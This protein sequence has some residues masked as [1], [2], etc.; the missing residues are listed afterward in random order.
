[1][2]NFKIKIVSVFFAAAFAVSGVALPYGAKAAAVE[3]Y[4]DYTVR[5][6]YSKTFNDI[7]INGSDTESAEGGDIS[8]GTYEDISNALIW[9]SQDGS[10]SYKFKTEGDISCNIK[11]SY[12][13]ISDN[14]ADFE[15]GLLIDGQYPFE[16]AGSLKLP[17]IWTNAGEIKTDLNGN[18]NTP[19]QT[20]YGKLTEKKLYDPSGSVPYELLFNFSGGE[21]TITLLKK[22][23]AVVISEI[24]LT[25]PEEALDYGQTENEYK[26]LGYKEYAGE[27]VI[28]EGEDAVLK[29][30]RSLVP[31]SDNTSADIRPNNVY[32]T[33]LNYIGDTNWSEP[34]EELVWY[35]DVPEDGLYKIGFNYKQDKVIN[36]VSYRSLKIDGEYPFEEAKNLKFTYGTSWRFMSAGDG[37]KDYLFYLTEGRHSLS[38]AV[39]MGEISDYYVVM[40]DIVEKIGDMYLKI[41]TIT[42][43]SP[44]SNRDY[45][46]FRQIP[47]F[48]ETLKDYKKTLNSLAENMKTVSGKR[49]SQYIAA[50]NNMERVITSMIE[51]PYT[52]QNYVSDYYSNYTTLGS[53]LSEMKSMP[54]S[55][56]SIQLATPSKA[57]NDLHA[58]FFEKIGFSVKRFMVSFIV[59]YNNVSAE[60]SENQSLKIWVNWGRDQ[61]MV[62]DS[63]IR[64]SFTPNTGITVNLELTN[65]SL[66]KGILSDIQPDL[67]LH[68]SRTEP[69]NLAMRGALYDLN[70]FSDYD[71]IMKR[72]DSSA[73]EPYRYKNGNYALPDTQAFYMMFYR[74]D[75][76]EKFG[77]SVPKTWNE[78][79]DTMVAVQRNNLQVYLPYIQITAATTVNTG[80][81]GLNLFPSVLM[82]F[83]GRVYDDS[84]SKAELDNATAFSAFSF[85]TDFYTKYKVPAVSNFYNRFR[86]GTSPLG[87]ETYTFYTTLAEAAPEIDGKWGIALVPGVEKEDGTVDHTVSGSG[88]GCAIL[89]KSK[90][91]EAAWEFLK[92]WTSADTQL[93]YNNNVE[94]ILGAVSRTTT[95]NVEA[96]ANMSWNREDLSLLLEQRK[97]IK[98]IPEVPGSYYLSRAVDQ[99]FWEVYNKN[100]NPKDT[101]IKWNDVAN[102]E[103]ARKIKEYSN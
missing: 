16:T 19:E 56:D 101:L 36:G 59:D 67:A 6:N 84:Q 33:V 44:D 14:G 92:W 18:E 15:F 7:A 29:S 53:W 21:H 90:N 34:G 68:L 46:L 100:A 80:L 98:E 23:G 96:F 79:I 89:E 57:Y 75:V 93:K 73:G 1:M 3:K 83:G 9:K 102:G 61:A 10:V 13:S 11:I 82:Q 41:V 64:E 86:V 17:Q 49:G 20:A 74:K 69:V 45:D 42:G 99:A 40:E 97:W 76:F 87:I 91:K 39:T 12:M 26:A 81:G 60:D 54:L 25:A 88:T 77:L 55:L 35:I 28:I 30:T 27:P 70:N 24:V 37:E 48:S 71:E 43:T 103:I 51:N 63:L 50:V 52:A 85:W 4:S 62:L 95:A 38:M 2:N 31:K 8:V 66:I 72:F 47:D 32:K 78:F 22:S 94:S 58:G 5:S 65:A